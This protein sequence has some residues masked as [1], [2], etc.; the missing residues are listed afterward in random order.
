M[1]DADGRKGEVPAD[2]TIPAER[3]N[4]AGVRR[5]PGAGLRTQQLKAVEI[6]EQRRI[7]LPGSQRSRRQRRPEHRRDAG[8]ALFGM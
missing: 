8:P 5:D 2:G 4:L 3:S 1:P 6:A 7:K